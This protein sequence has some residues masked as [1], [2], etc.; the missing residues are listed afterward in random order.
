MG[1]FNSGLLTGVLVSGALVALAVASG[2]LAVPPKRDNLVR[3]PKGRTSQRRTLAQGKPPG[4]SDAAWAIAQQGMTPIKGYRWNLSGDGALN[5][6]AFG[7][8]SPL[9]GGEVE[10][11]RDALIAALRKQGVKAKGSIARNAF[12]IGDGTYA[13]HGQFVEGPGLPARGLRI[14][15]PSRDMWLAEAVSAIVPLHGK[16][17]SR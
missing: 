10:D 12:M 8:Y 7:A 3:P 6:D 17:A 5:S 16:K 14:Q 1:N 9:T 4:M 13:I 15:R 2:A 11:L